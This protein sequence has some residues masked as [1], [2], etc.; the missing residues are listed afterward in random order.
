MPKLPPNRSPGTTA[1]SIDVQSRRVVISRPHIAVVIRTHS[2][3]SKP[4][5]I[6]AA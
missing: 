3:T 1:R 6:T 2:S 4:S 5:A